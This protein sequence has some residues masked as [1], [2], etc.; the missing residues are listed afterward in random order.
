M[1]VRTW[2]LDA[3]F[4]K[5]VHTALKRLHREHELSQHPLTGLAVVE[6]RRR[7][8]GLSDTPMGRAAALRGVLDEARQTLAAQD[9][10]AAALLEGRFWRGESVIQLTHQQ[11]VAEGTLYAQQLETISAL[12]RALWTLEQAAQKDAELRRSQCARNIPPPSYARLFGFDETFER[13]CAALTDAGGPW[14]VSIE[15]LGG[16]G[17]TALAHRAAAW[18]ADGNYFADIAWETLQQQQFATWSGIIEGLGA[19]QPLTYEAL[20]DSI[21]IQLGY[22]ELSGKS[23][24]QQVA[25]MQAVLKQQ[26]HL[27]VVDGL[28]TQSDRDALVPRLWELANPTRFLFTSRYSLCALSHVFCLTLNELSEGDSLALLRYEGTERDVRTIAEADDA[29]LRRIY[30][31]TGGHPLAIKLVVGQA[32]T[33]PL[34]RAL[35]QLQQV[36]GRQYEDLYRFIYWRSW[37]MLNDDARRVLLA[38][39]ALAASGGYWEN[40]QAATSLEAAR[41]DAAIEQLAAMSLL[42]TAGR[43]EKRYTIHRLTYTFIMSELLGEWT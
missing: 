24:A 36:A 35:V 23:P 27:V 25:R 18:A 4:V 31:V 32:R 22:S 12:A 41:L 20:L 29:M 13:L 5:Q 6:A 2:S 8:R 39:P 9:V 40:L 37:E 42:Q 26:P 43:D 10:D 16:L 1:E 28:E 21:A 30:A 34:E 38:M 33:L 17:K 14:L 19:R 3:E 15:G 7:Q 11:H